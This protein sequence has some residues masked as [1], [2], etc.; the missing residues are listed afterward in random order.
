M[1]PRTPQFL[2]GIR[3][4]SSAPRPVAEIPQGLLRPVAW[5]SAQAEP[6]APLPLQPLAPA[7]TTA[8]PTSEPPAGFEPLASTSPAVPAAAPPQATAQAEPSQAAFARL[9]LAIEALRLEGARLAEQT[10]ADALEVGL[11][12]ARR[13]LER[14]ISTN[15]EALFSLIKSA[16]RRAG[17]DHVT[18]VRLCPSD[19]ERVKAP[20]DERLSLGPVELRADEA[21][22]PGDVMV[23]TAHHTVDGRLATRLEEIGRA[24]ADDEV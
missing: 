3:P 12:V 11:L 10:R 23:D 14:E 13:V 19:L 4:T 24:L 5:A 9:E 6:A 21:L 8:G 20:P 17:E 18:V 16:I 1:L 7:A 15:L 2:E 22:A